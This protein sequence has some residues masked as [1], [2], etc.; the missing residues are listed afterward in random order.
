MTAKR[1][2]AAAIGLWWLGCGGMIAF[3]AWTIGQIALP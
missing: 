3:S 2:N 1:F